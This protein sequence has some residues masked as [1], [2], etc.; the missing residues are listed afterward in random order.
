MPSWWT[1]P[2]EW[3][4]ETAVVIAGGPSLT[5]ED[6]E[7]CRDKCRAIAVNNQ[8]I[9]AKINGV[10][11]PA[12]APWADVL[13]AADAKWW[14]QYAPASLSFAGRKITIRD[15]RFQDVNVLQI[16]P[17]VVFDPRP[18][19]IATGGNSGYQALHVAVHFGAKRILLLGF[20]MKADRKKR[21]HWFGDH[22]GNLNAPGNYKGW[23][24]AFGRIAPVLKH[25]GIE[26]INC[27]RDT[28]LTCFPRAAITEV[29]P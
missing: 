8:G 9:D 22:P 24:R 4:G 7:H 25:R 29:L 16:S 15:H 20:D 13:Y 26:V 18:T 11:Y 21:K 12:M 3:V 19:H 27:S 23:E 6:V 10:F 5:R 1:I 2:R 17:D 28:A 14:T